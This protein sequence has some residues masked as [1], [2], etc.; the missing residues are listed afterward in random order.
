MHICV[1]TNFDA[2][3]HEPVRYTLSYTPA[4]DPIYP[5]P[6]GLY[7]KV[8]N[9]SATP[10]RA[11]YLHGP[12]TLYAACYPS[13]FNPNVTYD[14]PD[15][16]GFPQFEPYLKAGGSWVAII[17]IPQ[18]IRQTPTELSSADPESCQSVTWVIEI[19]SQVVFSSTAVVNFEVLVGRDE[20]SVQLSTGGVSS[21]RPPL[22]AQLQDHWS[23]KTRGEQVLATAGVYSK[24]ISLQVDDTA[25]LWNSPPFPSFEENQRDEAEPSSQGL[26]AAANR[27]GSA[28]HQTIKPPKSATKKK[29]KK[30]HLVVLT[31]GLH[32]NLGADMLYLKESIDVAAKR[33]R[34]QSKQNRQASEN[35]PVFD[36]SPGLARSV[37]RNTFVRSHFVITC[38][39]MVSD[40]YYP[41]G[42]LVTFRT[43]ITTVKKTMMTSKS[44][45]EV[46]SEMPFVLNVVSSILANALRN[47]FCL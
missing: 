6:A 28:G 35:C 15:A 9:T 14:Q 47:M 7:V 30:V 13:T 37:A 4:A 29:K 2:D 20:K 21:T 46:S 40:E 33:A 10:L 17:T 45:S 32:S 5:P 26:Q 18:R 41:I 24:A 25:S 8:K 27:T 34:E 44:L 16:E 22:P 36:N 42:F 31:H 19:V 1:V 43:A 3:I 39:V 12:Y 38:I 23:P 11:A